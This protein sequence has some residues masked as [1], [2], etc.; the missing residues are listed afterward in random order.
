MQLIADLIPDGAS[1]Q[2]EVGPHPDH[3]SLA[4]VAISGV[5]A[6]RRDALGMMIDERLDPLPL[7]HETAWR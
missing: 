2:V 5:D 6:P 1:L 7:R 3:E 4:V